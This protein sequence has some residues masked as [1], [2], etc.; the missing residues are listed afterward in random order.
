MTVKVKAAFDGKRYIALPDDADVSV[1]Q[2]V[3]A[4]EFDM[5]E[6][7]VFSIAAADAVVTALPSTKHLDGT[8]SPRAE[9]RL[10]PLAFVQV[11]TKEL[12]KNGSVVNPVTVQSLAELGLSVIN[13]VYNKCAE[14]GPDFLK[15]LDPPSTVKAG[16][17]GTA[18]S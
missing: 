6:S 15:P 17:K 16:A 12:R 2:T 3:D 7:G 1:Y 4:F 18:P 5:N 9:E 14:P 13:V 8:R 11:H 10:Y